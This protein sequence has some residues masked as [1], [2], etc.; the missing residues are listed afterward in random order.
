MEIIKF[1][2]LLCFT[3]LF[4]TGSDPVQFLKEF[5]N[6]HEGSTSKNLAI[7]TITKFVNCDLCSGFWIGFAVYQNIWMACIIS[8]AAEGFGRLLAFLKFS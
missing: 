1:I 2:G 3:W 7:K 6:I 4:T 5:L 8:I